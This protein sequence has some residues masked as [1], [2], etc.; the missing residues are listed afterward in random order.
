MVSSL[1]L[2]DLRNEMPLTMMRFYSELTQN[3]SQKRRDYIDK[4]KE[5]IRRKWFTTPQAGN[6]S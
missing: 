4:R 2:V 5:E 3:I 6:P 1:D